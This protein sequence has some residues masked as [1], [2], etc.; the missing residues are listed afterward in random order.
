MNVNK[1]SLPRLRFPAHFRRARVPILRAPRQMHSAAPLPSSASSKSA[2]TFEQVCHLR[3]LRSSAAHSD[4]FDIFNFFAIFEIVAVSLSSDSRWS[5]GCSRP[6]RLSRL[7]SQELFYPTHSRYPKPGRSV[8]LRN[9]V[10]AGEPQSAQPIVIAAIGASATLMCALECDDDFSRKSS[11]NL[12]VN[13][14]RAAIT[15]RPLQSDCPDAGDCP[16]DG[17]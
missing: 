9:S 16:P 3:H 13:S 17:R 5:E 8:K 2:S 11:R 12:G 1:K 6:C 7:F 4:I 10:C 15:R 14:Y